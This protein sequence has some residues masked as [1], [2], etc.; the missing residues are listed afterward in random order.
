MPC[1][2]VQSSLNWSAP[3]AGP[4]LV[5]DGLQS[6]ARPTG[7]SFGTEAA[8]FLGSGYNATAQDTVPFAL[9]CA[10]EHLDNY[11]EALWQTV[12]G[13]GDRD[14][15]CAIVGGI[16][17]LSA[18]VDPFPPPGGRRASRCPA[19][20]LRSRMNCEAFARLLFPLPSTPGHACTG[21]R[22]VDSPTRGT[23]CYSLS[24]PSKKAGSRPFPL[25]SLWCLIG[26]SKSL[27]KHSRSLLSGGVLWR[28]AMAFAGAEMRSSAAEVP[29]RSG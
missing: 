11:E 18:G 24:P 17:A 8:P 21:G 13:L 2:S 4:G 16:V 9:W 19:G 7:Q 28:D 1:R 26:M 25:F 12:S 6:G 10:G 20:R 27:M 15:N 14:T 22:K 23:T 3:C 29:S 5:R